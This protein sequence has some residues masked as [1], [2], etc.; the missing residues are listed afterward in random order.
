MD[1]FPGNSQRPPQ[2]KQ[3]KVEPTAAPTEP[4]TEPKRIEKIVTGEVVQRKRPMSRRL[5]ETFIGGD[6]QSVGQYVVGDVLVPAAKDMFADALTQFVERMIFGDAGPRS[7][8]PRSTGGAVRT[9]LKNGY[10][11]YDRVAQG[12][13]RQDPRNTGSQI[14]RRARATHDFNEIILESRAEADA[15]LGQMYDL[16]QEYDLV[17][18]AELYDMVGISSNFVEHKFGWT[19]LAGSGVQRVRGGGGYVLVLPSP[20]QLD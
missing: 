14:S 5:K 3:K 11:S 16:L 17:K 10:T 20:E 12:P 8:G 7:R 2:S 18:V 15:V 1:E 13:I 4:K 9:I 6:S 19:S